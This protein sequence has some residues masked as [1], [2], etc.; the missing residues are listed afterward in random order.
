MLENP[1]A[2]VSRSSAAFGG[3][4]PCSQTL[5]EKAPNPASARDDGSFL[6]CA[7]CWLYRAAG[8]ADGRKGK[9]NPHTRTG[10]PFGYTLGF[11]FHS[12]PKVSLPVGCPVLSRSAFF[13][14]F[15]SNAG[16]PFQ[17]RPRN[18][19]SSTWALAFSLPARTNTHPPC[20]ARP[21]FPAAVKG[22]LRRR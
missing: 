14:H 6:D 5:Q 20:A 12:S 4:G 3:R 1:G 8:R 2:V 9:E 21:A 7:G 18:R 10:V 16:F 15:W 19:L 13:R 17:T 11:F 22:S